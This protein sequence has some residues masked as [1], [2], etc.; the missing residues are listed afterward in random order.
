MTGL[1]KMKNQILEEAQALA[2]SKIADAQAQAERILE[3]A[4]AEALKSVEYL[5]QKSEMDTANYR[6]RI[7]SSIDLQKRTKILQAK[8]DMI[9]EI[10]DQSYEKLDRMEA[11][12]YFDMILKMIGKYALAQDGI[13]Y[14]GKADMARMPVG[15]QEKVRKAAAAKGGTLVIS[16][17]GRNIENGFVLAYGGIEENC[18]LKV[19]FD[20]KKDELTDKIH[21]L[22]F[23]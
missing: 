19:I 2:D 23:A 7:A 21:R 14:F 13:I 6:E 3:E 22:L 12:E 15:Y 8:Q 16:E 10:L 20:A 9:K 4:K 17:E 18:T 5:S 1:E 11:G